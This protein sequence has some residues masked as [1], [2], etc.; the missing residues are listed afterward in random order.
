MNEDSSLIKKESIEALTRVFS[1]LSHPT[2][3]RILALCAIKERS[4]K[5]LRELLGI[6][7]PLLLAHLRVLLK[8]GLLEYRTAIDEDKLVIKKFYRTAR[9]KLCIDIEMFTKLLSSFD[10]QKDQ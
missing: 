2:R 8:A 7:K 1:A 5:E 10:I 6:S 9:L 3:L 4:T